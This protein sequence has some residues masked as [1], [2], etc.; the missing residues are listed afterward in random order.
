MSETMSKNYTLYIK[1][2]T[3]ETIPMARLAQYMQN[4]A[5]MLGHDTAVHFDTLKPGST[6][7]V[8]KIDHEDV[9]KVA[10]H[11]AQVKRGD[12]SPEATR[13]KTEIDR[14]LAE[15]NAT[16]FVYEDDDD[17]AEIIAFPGVNRPKPTTYGPFN[18]EGTLD[19]ILISVSGADQTVHLQLQNGEIKYT[20]I[21]T[22]RDTARRLAKHMYEPVRIFGTGRW[23]RDQDGNWILKKFRVDNFTVLAPDDLKDAIDQMREIKGS[24]WANMDDPIGA[25]KALREKG[26]GL[27]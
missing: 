3:P 12:G 7:L 5:A 25:L 26:N 10:A 16:G 22:N 8:T 1:A 2:Y 15:D 4:L 14:L 24:E 11:I 6:Q 23:L 17:S 19:G 27:H 9:P 18:Q 20:G 13:A 21:D